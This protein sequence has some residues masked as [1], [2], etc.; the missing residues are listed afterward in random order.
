MIKGPLNLTFLLYLN[1][2][3][4]YDEKNNTTKIRL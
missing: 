2:S 1:Y 4:Y 3:T